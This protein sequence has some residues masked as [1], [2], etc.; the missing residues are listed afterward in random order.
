M[1]WA[2]ALVFI[3]FPWVAALADTQPRAFCPTSWDSSLIYYNSFENDKPEILG[4]KLQVRAGI[5][6]APGGIRGRCGMPATRSAIIDIVASDDTLSPHRPLTIMLW[7]AP[8]RMYTLMPGL[9]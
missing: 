9:A 3:S 7:W 4:D 1:R 6:S 8:W 5:P 2:A